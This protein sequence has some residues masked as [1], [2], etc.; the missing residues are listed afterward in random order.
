M[1]VSL[2]LFH[3]AFKDRNERF[4][5]FARIRRDLAGT[6]AK[7]L[8][9]GRHTD[10]YES[11]YQDG[12]INQDFGASYEIEREFAMAM[13]FGE[14]ASPEQVETCIRE[15]IQ[16]T[17]RQG[18]SRE[19]FEMVR[20]AL[21]G[22][23][24]KRLNSPESFGTMMALSYLQGVEGFDYFTSCGTITFDEVDSVFREVFLGDMAV[25]IVEREGSR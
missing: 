4:E 24:I 5:G 15:H 7:D 16:R 1:D 23:M 20:A 14:T 22:K 9:F 18:L 19:E 13:I 10:F 17:A 2:P 3:F 6:I 21:E 11:L 25:S 12:L 8:L